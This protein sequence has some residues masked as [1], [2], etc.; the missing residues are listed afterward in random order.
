MKW[1]EKALYELKNTLRF[2]DIALWYAVPL[3]I[4]GRLRVI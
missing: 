4:R 1:I 2:K 3:S